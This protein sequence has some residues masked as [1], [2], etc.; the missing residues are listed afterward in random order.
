ML[1]VQPEAVIAQPAEISLGMGKVG[2][3]MPS[4]GSI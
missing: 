1:R 2:G 4:G 3:S